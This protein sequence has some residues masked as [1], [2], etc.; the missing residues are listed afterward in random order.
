[1]SEGV[2]IDGDRRRKDGS[3]EEEDDHREAAFIRWCVG[4]VHCVSRLQNLQLFLVG[5]AGRVPGC[6][7]SKC[8]CE[9]LWEHWMGG[10]AKSCAFGSRQWGLCAVSA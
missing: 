6:E 1:M 8:V 10:F 7:G 4:R 3:Q 2:L 9:N 5:D